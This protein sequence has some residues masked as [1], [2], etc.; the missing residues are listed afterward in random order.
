MSQRKY[1]ADKVIVCDYLFYRF[2][3]RESYDWVKLPS[4][5]IRLR[6]P[7][8]EFNSFALVDSGSNVT[9][10]MN[11]QAEI[12]SLKPAIRDGKPMTAEVT[13]AGGKFLADV[14]TIPELDAMKRDV[15][16]AIFRGQQ[17]YVPSQEEAIPYAILGRDTIF[18]RFVI[19][20]DDNHQ[21][22]IFRRV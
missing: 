14:F 15:P 9:L 7:A 13:G 6:S 3:K 19:S 2:R 16:F 1:I 12:L 10:L 5:E 8:A 4:V 18:R 17:V 11:Q 20:F 22:L 21:K